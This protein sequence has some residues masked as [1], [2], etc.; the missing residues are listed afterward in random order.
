MKDRL[1]RLL[2]GAPLLV[3]AALAHADCDAKPGVSRVEGRDVVLAF[4]TRPVKIKVGEL[5]GMDVS[6][7]AK[8]RTVKGLA[9]DASMPEH[10]HGMNYKPTVTKNAVDG[11]SANGMLFHMPGRWQFA[12]D[13]TT[14]TGSERLL[15]TVSID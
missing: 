10:K 2:I 8:Q 14:S 1:C 9:V 7:C 15:H 5:F 3:G 6:V 11:F 12:F 13:V 4:K